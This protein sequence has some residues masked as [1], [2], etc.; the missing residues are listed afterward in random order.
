[1]TRLLSDQLNI[2]HGS[3]P[4]G[5][6]AGRAATTSPSGGE[7]Q[8]S[9]PSPFTCDCGSLTDVLFGTCRACFNHWQE[10]A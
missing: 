6:E 5:V 4:V 9:P 10:A 2:F 7:D 8:A 1:M 3:A